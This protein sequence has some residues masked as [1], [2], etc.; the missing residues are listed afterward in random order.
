MSA[1]HHHPVPPKEESYE[2]GRAFSTTLAA[3]ALAVISGIISAIGAFHAPQQFA[4]SW[5]FAFAFFFTISVGSLFW[6][7]VHHA[8]D[9]E[10]GVLIRRIQ[11][12]MAFLLPVLLLFFIPLYLYRQELWHW[13]FL[14]PGADHV[15]DL[16]RGFINFPFSFVAD[17][18]GKDALKFASLGFATRSLIYFAALSGL[19]L[20]MYW[21]STRQDKDGAPQHTLAM[22]MVGGGGLP[23]FCLTLTFCGSDWLMALDKHWN[24][25]LW[26]VYIFAGGVGSSMCLLVVITYWLQSL[27]YLKWVTVEHYHIMGKLML[28]FCAF[29]AY[30]AFSQY[31]LDWYGNIP[32]ETSY[33]IRRSIGSW[34]HLTTFLTIFRFFIPFPI[35]LIQGL[36]RKPKLLMFAALWMLLMQ[37]IDLYI[38]IMP[39]L[40]EQGVQVSIL[41]LSCLVFFASVLFLIFTRQ[42]SKHNLF[43]L[44][45]PR[46]EG[47]IKL[48]N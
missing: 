21:H 12:T 42:L 4:F 25:T 3:V 8:T 16:K 24:S 35:L 30:I 34:W 19:A 43:P 10:W 32:E 31:M 29:W 28:A 37:L 9:A 33:F 23:L 40:H 18:Y 15:V 26:G 14:V 41:D 20:A 27:G 38:I 47:S 46:L 5:L 45:D 11:E 48:L 1:D 7:L 2:S 44:R 17:G 39:P 22:R 6:L 36:K 13:L